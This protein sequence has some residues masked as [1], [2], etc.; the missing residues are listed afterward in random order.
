MSLGVLA[1]AALLGMS[2]SGVRKAIVRGTLRATKSPDGA[3]LVAAEEVSRYRA[4][5]R[6]PRRPAR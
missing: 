5:H 1:V 6:K 3:Y 4:E 2:R